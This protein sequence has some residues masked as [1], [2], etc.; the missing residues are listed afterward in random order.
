VRAPLRG[1]TDEEHAQVDKLITEWLES[2]S[3][4][5]AR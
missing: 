1:L 4:V 2:S 3:P 5:Q